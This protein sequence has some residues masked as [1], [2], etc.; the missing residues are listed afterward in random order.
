MTV[1]VSHIDPASPGFTEHR[2]AHLRLIER[3]RSAEARVHQASARGRAKFEARGQLLPRDRLILLLDRGAPFVELSTL[4]GYR[5]HDDDGDRNIAGG[6]LITGIGFVSGVRCMVLI[7]DAGI[8]GGALTPIGVEKTLRA[9]QIAAEQKLPYIQLIQSAGANLKRQSEMFVKGGQMFANLARLSALGLPVISAVN[10]SSTAGGAYQAGLSDYIVMVRN[11]SRVF[12][13]GPPLLKAATGEIAEEED[14][15]GAEMHCEITGTGEY[16]AEDDADAIRIVRDIVAR[17]GWNENAAISRAALAPRHDPEELLGVVPTDY[18]KPYDAREVIARLIDDSD[19][20]DFKPKFGISTVTGHARLC[21]HPVGVIANNGPIDANGAAKVGQFIQLCCQSGTPL[22]FLQ[23]TTGFLVGRNVE[24]A[25][26]VK[27]G[28]KMIQAVTNASVPRLTILIGASFGAGNY[29]MCGRGLS[30]DF[31]F[32]WP[33]AR[34][35]VMGGEQ[36]AR[37]LV[38]VAEGTARSRGETPDHVQLD[39]LASEIVEMYDN[40]SEALYATARLWDDGLI[41]PRDTRRILGFCLDTCREA[42]ARTLR[43]SGFGVPRF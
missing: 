26:I 19:F 41:D 20:L 13:A 30:P 24:E 25:G 42:A 28:S 17:L 33:N 1:I 7:S 29:A 36:A 8:R 3:L 35:A 12:L 16:L 37:T 10:G 22:L 14:L 38:T 23:N 39:T 43:P 6:G 2:Q 21:G 40:E 9:Q 32:A 11:R 5:M 15:G 27:H 4:C 34:V 31:L 18:R